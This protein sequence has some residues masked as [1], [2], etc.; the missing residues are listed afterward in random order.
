[1]SSQPS[2]YEFSEADTCREY[3]TPVIQAAGWLTSVYLMRPARWPDH[4]RVP[5]VLLF[6]RR[7]HDQNVMRHPV[8]QEETAH[9]A[10][11]N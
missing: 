11:R 9:L 4:S 6:D 10:C 1:M 2:P 8:V 7:R 3:V 5:T